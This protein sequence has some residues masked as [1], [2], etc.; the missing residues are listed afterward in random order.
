V[1][2]RD[3]VADPPPPVRAES[4]DAGQERAEHAEADRARGEVETNAAVVQLVPRRRTGQRRI[5]LLKDWKYDETALRASASTGDNFA[6][7]G[8][9]MRTVRSSP[10]ND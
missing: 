2:V 3:A 9:L 6:S 10:R 8:D 7:K 4:A 5:D 1:A